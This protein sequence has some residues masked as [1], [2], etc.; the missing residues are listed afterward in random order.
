[1]VVHLVLVERHLLMMSVVVQFVLHVRSIVLQLHLAPT[2]LF[3]Q[4]LLIALLDNLR[5]VLLVIVDRLLVLILE[6]VLFV[7][8]VELGFN[9]VAFPVLLV[10][11]L[12]PAYTVAVQFVRNVLLI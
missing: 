11:V 3:L 12:L 4:L 1:M 8:S 10:P 5:F 2:L 6:D 7:T 9:E